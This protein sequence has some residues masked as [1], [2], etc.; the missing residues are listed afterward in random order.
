[1]LLELFI[2]ANL[3]FLLNVIFEPNDF[4]SKIIVSISLTFGKFRILTFLFDSNVAAKIG[5]EEFLDPEI[6][7]VPLSFFDPI[8]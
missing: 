5:S 3:F 1:M 4:K 2:C 6:F 7:I 8:T